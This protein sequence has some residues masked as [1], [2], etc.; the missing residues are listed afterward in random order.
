MRKTFCTLNSTN[1]V[2]LLAD[3]I[4][5][6]LMRADHVTE[7]QLMSLISDT[8]SKLAVGSQFGSAA[9]PKPLPAYA[10]YR[11]GVG[12]MLLNVNN[13]VFVGHRIKTKGNAWQMPQGGIEAGGTLYRRIARIERGNRHRR[14]GHFSRKQEL[15]AL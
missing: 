10:N 15:A 8:F 9:H 1:M 7:Q 4:V 14:R 11:R 5:Q 3:P 12:I 6:M 13:D 2:E